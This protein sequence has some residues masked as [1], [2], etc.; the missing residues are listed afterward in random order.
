MD[1]TKIAVAERCQNGSETGNLDFPGIVGL[2]AAEGFDGYLV[3]YRAGTVTYYLEDGEATTL[4]AGHRHVPVPAAFDAAA[5]AAAIGEAQRKVAG[6]TYAGFSEK[7]MAAGCA[8]YLVSLSGRRVV[9]FGRSGETH[10]ERMP[11]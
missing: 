3:D 4:Q 8:G 11:G 1:A 6:Y 2:L 5:V 9:Y 10:V 7:V